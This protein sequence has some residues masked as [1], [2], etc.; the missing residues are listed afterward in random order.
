[1]LSKLP[2]ETTQLLVEVCSGTSPDLTSPKDS[3]ESIN[4]TSGAV[5]HSRGPSAAIPYLS[6]LTYNRSGNTES[7][8]PNSDQVP[9]SPVPPN[10]VESSQVSR[11]PT[12]AEQSTHLE[13][14]VSSTP[15]ITSKPAPVKRPAPS[16]YFA[17]FVHHPQYFIQ[18]LEA[19]AFN[20]WR[21]RVDL[22]SSTS[23]GQTS[24]PLSAADDKYDQAAVWNTL[25]EL[26]L[27]SSQEG[28]ADKDANATLR[29]KAIYVLQNEK[30][31]PY[32]ATHALIVCSTQSFTEGLV[33]LWEK[34]GMYED[35]LRFWMDRSERAYRG[36]SSE[37]D[38]SPEEAS[39]RVV[40]YLKLYG[41]AHPHLYTL[42]LRFL[43]SSPA[44][45]SRHTDDLANVLEHINRE[46]IIPPVGVIQ[47]LSRNEVSSVG[48]VKDWLMTRIAESRDEI[49]AVR[50]FVYCYVIVWRTYI[51]IS[52]L[53]T[54]S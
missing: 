17:H 20:R 11:E 42:V 1:M 28:Q 45:L 9:A 31:L 25:L 16:Q 52:S 2:Q 26:Y 21:Q 10:I 35:V 27:T 33:L 30:V 12:T 39:A 36:D 41:P 18:F 50:S 3:P 44:L 23:T 15:T 34:M 47:I 53:R 6:Y 54:G 37:T 8:N 13:S 32:D 22:E 19:V 7:P 14:A 43:T 24:S 38:G 29:R 4:G 46:K 48:L 5:A 51:Q 49:D 40:Q